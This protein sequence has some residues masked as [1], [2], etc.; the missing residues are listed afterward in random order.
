LTLGLIIRM[1]LALVHVC[2]SGIR[3]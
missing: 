1:I 2:Q 3:F